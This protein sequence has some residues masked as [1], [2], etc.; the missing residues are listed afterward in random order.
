MILV[1]NVPFLCLVPR[2]P[3]KCTGPI[4]K[5]E[6]AAGRSVRRG[7]GQRTATSASRETATHF[8][9][10]AIMEPLMG[11]L[12]DRRP[13]WLFAF[14][15]ALALVVPN[16]V[17]A[18]AFSVGADVGVAVPLSSSVQRAPRVDADS[19]TTVGASGTPSLYW[20]RNGTG[21]RLGLT[22]VFS[23]VELRYALD[24]LPWAREDQRCIGDRDASVLGNGEVEDA[25]V[26]YDCSHSV[27]HNLRSDN[28]QAL[29]LHHVSAGLRLNV[30]GLAR[31]RLYGAGALGLIFTP[32]SAFGSTGGYRFGMELTVGGGVDLDVVGPVTFNVDARYG[33]AL[34]DSAASPE[35]GANRAV[36]TG[37]NVVQALFDHYNWFTVTAQIRIKFE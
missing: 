34:I 2:L 8:G 21:L 28:L 4:R 15:F 36:A 12:A 33:F 7:E 14:A 3:L 17:S 35:A 10:H 24:S 32:Y 20:K 22:A 18:E 19:A 37:G 26:R 5:K 29:P 23:G 27:R 25:A 1:V 30:P 16:I 31:P 9:V 11:S 13:L 6:R